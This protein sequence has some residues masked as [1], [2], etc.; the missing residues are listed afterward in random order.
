MARK[1]G[2]AVIQE[3]M[4][5]WLKSTNI[6]PFP[7]LEQQLSE[8]PEVLYCCEDYRDFVEFAMTTANRLETDVAKRSQKISVNVHGHY[9]SQEDR[10]LAKEK[11][12]QR[13]HEREL[14][15]RRQEASGLHTSY[16]NAYM[17]QEED[18]DNLGYTQAAETKKPSKKETA[19]TKGGGGDKGNGVGEKPLK[20]GGGSFDVESTGG[21]SIHRHAPALHPTA[22]GPLGGFGALNN[23]V[24][25]QMKTI[26]YQLSSQ[27]CLEEG[28]TL[29]VPS[30]LNLDDPDTEIFV[31]EPFHPM[32]LVSGQVQGREIIQKFYPNGTPFLII[33]PDGT[34]NVFY[35]SGRI[36]ILITSVT[37]GQNTYVVLD[38]STESQILAVFD[39]TG[40]GTCYFMDGK[41]RLNYDQ[42]GGIELDLT[43][44]RRR[45]W[46]W[47]D[48]ETHVHA[49]PF[50]PIV[51]GMNYFLSVRVMSQE[52]IALSL[53]GK[54]RSCRFNVGTKLKMVMPENYL[55]KFN[56]YQLYIDEHKLQIQS[57]MIKVNNLL[58]FPKSPKLDS[59]LPPVSLTSKQFKVNQKRQQL[60]SLSPR[61][62]EKRI[63]KQHRLPPLDQTSVIVN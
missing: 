3:V 54:K 60:N 26:N 1:H 61:N 11:A 9:G 44:S 37:L 20:G 5:L 47:K 13:M 21:H 45:S 38:D 52:N 63:T 36:A 58:K 57:L 41:I 14:Q 35:P 51:F 17:Y 46:I 33:F 43:G 24:S 27:R 15:R 30:P 50:Q 18:S 29:R 23:E 19:G 40:C 39:A 59:M 25:R 31:P 55:D 7:S 8:P 62:K 34:G 49:P 4:E 12:V 22:G 48:H 16:Q 10:L 28:W 2:L 6:K 42:Q 53:T 56:E 32:A